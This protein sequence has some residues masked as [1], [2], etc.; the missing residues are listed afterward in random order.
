M[1]DI[2]RECDEEDKSATKL[3]KALKQKHRGKKTAATATTDE[4]AA[5]FPAALAM[6]E[7][8]GFDFANQAFDSLR[9]PCKLLPNNDRVSAAGSRPQTFGGKQLLSETIKRWKQD[10]SCFLD[11]MPNKATSQSVDTARK[12]LNKWEIFLQS[13]RPVGDDLIVGAE[14]YDRHLPKVRVD[15]FDNVMAWDAPKWSDAS[16]HLTHGFPRKLIKEQH[17]GYVAGNIV[18][19]SK[20]S[21]EMVRTFAQHDV[22][23]FASG[24]FISKTG[25]TVAELTH[26]RSL[27]VKL[28]Q[29]S[30]LDSTRLTE[31]MY[32]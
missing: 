28:R 16:V 5:F 32:R 17:G 15:I 2:A 4:A 29:T 11:T 14:P 13:G 10:Y 8:T 6:K 31:T 30:S 23:A 20:V 1:V 7:G 21:N 26:C 24:S 3:V 27:S 9:F 18:C 25:L 12:S 19:A 22:M